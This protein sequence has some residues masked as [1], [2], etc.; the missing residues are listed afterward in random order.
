[1]AEALAKYKEVKAELS[2]P[3]AKKVHFLNNRAKLTFTLDEAR[4]RAGKG[5]ASWGR[6]NGG[7][8]WRKEKEEKEKGTFLQ[9][10]VTRK[11]N[12]FLT[13]Y[14]QKKAEEQEEAAEEEATV[15]EPS[16]EDGEK[17]KKKKKKRK[18]EEEAE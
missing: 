11:K 3:P 7:W 15:E 14:V 6:S 10:S 17:K 5:G 16:T 8:K 2:Q 12:Y 9:F 1:M 4:T 18:L 13:Y